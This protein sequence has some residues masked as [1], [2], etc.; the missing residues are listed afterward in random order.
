[1][2]SIG[3]STDPRK[4]RAH[5]LAN[6]PL[7]T[8][9][10]TAEKQ[11]QRMGFECRIAESRVF[12]DQA[13]AE[14]GRVRFTD[15]DYFVCHTERSVLFTGHRAWVVALVFDPDRTVTNVLVQVFKVTL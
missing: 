5:I 8:R 1:M 6:I 14:N 12:E 4:A 2:R 9:L 7:G 3:L 13:S 15:I 11:L 10:D